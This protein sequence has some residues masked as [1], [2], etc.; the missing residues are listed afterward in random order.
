MSYDL[1]PRAAQHAFN[2]PAIRHPPVRR[3]ARIAVLDE[4][5]AWEIRIFER[6]HVPELVILVPL[7]LLLRAAHHALEEQLPSDFLNDLVQCIER[8]PE[9]VKDAEEQHIVELTC[10]LIDVVYR[11]LL[12]LNI[13]T[14]GLGGKAR[15]AEVS[16]IHVD[17]K[18]PTCASL[19]Q[20]DRIEAA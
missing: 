1:Q 3:V 11:A 15:L 5:H 20:S 16:V 10:D 13:Q 14:Q 17:A 4:V 6:V 8:I 19:L 7:P 12:K 18:H 2:C 9:M